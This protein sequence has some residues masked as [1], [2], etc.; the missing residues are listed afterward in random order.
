MV[1]VTVIN[2]FLMISSS[3][4]MNLR[5]KSH[6]KR[7]SQEPSLDELAVDTADGVCDIVRS[8]AI[9]VLLAGGDGARR[10]QR[11]RK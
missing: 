1:K 8:R 7:R 2:Y 6:P 3:K 5:R 4:T 9:G 11:T 10:T